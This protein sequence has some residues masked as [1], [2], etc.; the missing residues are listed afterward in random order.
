[1]KKF[2]KVGT[3]QINKIDQII[4]NTP[5]ESKNFISKSLEIAHQISIVLDERDLT[6]KNLAEMLGKSEAEISK[7]LCGMHN[8]TIRTIAHIESAL[9]EEIIVTPQKVKDNH[10]KYVTKVYRVAANNRNMRVP[11]EQKTKFYLT[12]EVKEIEIAA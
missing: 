5:A 8:F 2:R 3:V 9:G 1:M 6:Q 4:S 12:G 11:S 7:W 10:L